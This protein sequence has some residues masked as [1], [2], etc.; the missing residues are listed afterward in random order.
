MSRPAKRVPWGIEV[1]KDKEQTIYVWLDA[2]VNYYTVLGYPELDPR[3]NERFHNVIH[4]LGKDILR[5]HAIMW[6]GLLIANDYP[7]PQEL[8]V[9]NFWLM[10]NVSRL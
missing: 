9:H 7:L 6:P 10:N 8:I 4:I 1:P 2:L 5:F 3:D